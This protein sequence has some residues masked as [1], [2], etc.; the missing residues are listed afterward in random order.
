MNNRLNEILTS[1]FVTKELLD[2]IDYILDLIPELKN[3]IDF[4]QKH[5]HHHLDLFNHILTTLSLSPCDFEIRL[6]LLLHDIAKPYEYVEGDVR[7]YPNHAY[8][9]SCIAKNILTRLNYDDKL[10]DDIVKMIKYHDT[11]LLECNDIDLL[12]KLYIVQY[13][14]AYAHNPKYLDKRTNYLNKLKK[15][16]SGSL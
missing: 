14:D 8:N 10:I 15:K 3:S 2:N 13:C 9:S 5:P 1:E 6:T 4:D 16:V 7:H 12:K 11:D